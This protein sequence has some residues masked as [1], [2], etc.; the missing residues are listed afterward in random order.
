MRKIRIVRDD[1][2]EIREYQREKTG[3]L[4]PCDGE[5]HKN[6]HIDNCMVCAPRWGEVEEMAPVDIDK[7][8]A[9]RLAVR[10][11]D[12]PL[13]KAEEEEDAGCGRIEMVRRYAGK[14]WVSSYCVLIWS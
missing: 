8:R 9:E 3:R 7:A 4:V 14:R 12:L 1:G 6:P 10:V 5:A 2:T 11:A 13:G